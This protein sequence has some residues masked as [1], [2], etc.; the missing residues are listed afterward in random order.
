MGPYYIAGQYSIL[1]IAM[2]N[3]CSLRGSHAV[4]GEVVRWLDWR[5]VTTALYG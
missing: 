4:Q 2:A 1:L 3:I 5:L